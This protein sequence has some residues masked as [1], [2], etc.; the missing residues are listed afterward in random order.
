MFLEGI[1]LDEYIHMD[2]FL[3]LV[4][5]LHGLDQNEELVEDLNIVWVFRGDQP[6]GDELESVDSCEYFVR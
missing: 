4:V 2:E 3:H 6:F 1:V 5:K